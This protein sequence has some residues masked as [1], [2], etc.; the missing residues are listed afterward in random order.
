[1]S[2]SDF[3]GSIP[4]IGR[5]FSMVCHLSCRTPLNLL[6]AFFLAA[7]FFSAMNSPHVLLRFVQAVT[8]PSLVFS[9]ERS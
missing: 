2:S 3:A 7:G 9:W 8:P 1:M 5:S 6:A 4:L